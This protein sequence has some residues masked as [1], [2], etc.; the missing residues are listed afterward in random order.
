MP[1]G[2]SD[3]RPGCV[4]ECPGC[5]HRELSAAES[6]ER[7]LQWLKRVLEPWV[8]AIEPVRAVSGEARWR[9]RDKTCL[10]AEWN[11]SSWQLGLRVG[12]GDDERV[13]DIPDCPVHSDRVRTVMRE[14]ARVLPG[15]PEHLPLVFVSV[16]GGIATL[17]LKCRELPALSVFERRELEPLLARTGLDGFFVNLNPS[18]GNRVVSSKGWVHLAGSESSRAGPPGQGLEHGPESFQQLIPAL[19]EDALGEARAFLAPRDGDSVIDLCSGL[20]AS[21]RI[22]LGKGAR[23]I[24]VELSGESIRLSER[25]LVG[26][27]LLR[28]RCSERLPQLDAWLAQPPEAGGR[29]ERLLFANPPRLG[30]EPAVARWIAEDSRPRRV[31]YL[32]CSAGTL[33]RDLSVLTGSGYGLKRIIPYDFFPQTHHVETLAL[34]ERE[35]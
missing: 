7:K 17:V 3:L 19:Y 14:L 29:R 11:G 35:A 18:A 31:A 24:G 28:G 33:A 21:L 20:G 13:I 32:S 34:L 22:W 6:E 12:R 4:A 25:N 23:A 26:P 15:G 5:R 9:Y 27:H 2:I 8:R 10:R 30:L 16:T 1:E